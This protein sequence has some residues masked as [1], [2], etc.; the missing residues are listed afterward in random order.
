MSVRLQASAVLLSTSLLCSAAPPA[1]WSASG[2]VNSSPLNDNGALVQGQLKHFTRKAVDEMNMRFPEGAGTELNDI[3][4]GWLLNYQDGGYSPA[5]PMAVDSQVMTVGQL[6]WI[7]AKIHARLVYY[8]YEDGPPAW[9][10]AAP[11]ATDNDV[12]NLGQL[13]TVFNFNLTAPAGQTPL[14]WQKFYSLVGID[15]GGDS[16]G[17]GL[18]NYGEYNQGTTPSLGD[19]DD[20]GILDPVEL[21]TGHNPKIKD[22]PKLKLEV[23][24]Q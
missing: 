22:N 19:A 3:V 23:W 12:A 9:L 2:A 5:K 20:D 21:S 10:S 8:C 17:D 4:E 11:T 18:S 14:W 6:K 1:W 7:G 24:V 16:D 13:K 15:P